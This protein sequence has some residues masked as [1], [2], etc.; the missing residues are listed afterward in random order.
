MKRHVEPASDGVYRR[1]FPCL[2]TISMIQVVCRFPEV[3]DFVAV[4]N[5]R[6]KG[7]KAIR[8][9]TQVESNVQREVERRRRRAGE[10]SC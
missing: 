2:Q 8:D 6:E 4:L 5:G 9:E 10:I 7:C 1:V 3:E